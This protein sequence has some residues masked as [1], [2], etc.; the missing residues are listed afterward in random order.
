MS[1]DPEPLEP[2][3]PRPSHRTPAGRDPRADWAALS[4]AAEGNR[5]SAA[6]L[7]AIAESLSALVSASEQ[8]RLALETSVRRGIAIA[9]GVLIVSCLLSALTLAQDWMH[10]RA[11][12]AWNDSLK[13]QL[14]AQQNTEKELLRLRDERASFVARIEKLEAGTAMATEAA[15]G[16]ESAKAADAARGSSEAAKI[17]KTA[18]KAAKSSRPTRAAPR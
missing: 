3:E 6:Q 11:V 4:E 18:T 7:G 17:S 1:G 10:N 14:V 2:D 9:V 12:D 8:G 13:T 15:K 16:A 5:R